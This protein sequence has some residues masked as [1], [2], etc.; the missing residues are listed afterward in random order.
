MNS[1]FPVG[2][3]QGLLELMLLLIIVGIFS[4][5]GALPPPIDGPSL[6]LSNHPLE[7]SSLSSGGASRGRGRSSMV[8]SSSSSSSPPRTMEKREEEG[9]PTSLIK[10][11]MIDV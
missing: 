7:V 9:C 2:R 8:D 3:L 10:V 1:S 6:L 11:A 5:V 4:L